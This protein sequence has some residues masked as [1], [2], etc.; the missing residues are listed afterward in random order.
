MRTTKLA[1]VLKEITALIHSP[2]LSRNFSVTADDDT[3]TFAT[4]FAEHEIN[5]T[6]LNGDAGKYFM[7]DIRLLTV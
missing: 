2:D 1:C 3:L 5:P 6:L 7:F 4:T